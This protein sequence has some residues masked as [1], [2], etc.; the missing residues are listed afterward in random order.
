MQN[1]SW[2]VEDTTLL[3]ENGVPEPVFAHTTLWRVIDTV[4]TLGRSFRQIQYTQ[5][6]LGRVQITSPRINVDMQAVIASFGKLTIDSELLVPYHLFATSEDR[7]EITTPNGEVKEG[8]HQV[9]MHY[10][11][12]EIRSPDP[13]RRLR[14][15]P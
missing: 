15:S 1:Q 7:L 4:D 14:L 11:L 13:D 5:T 3:V 9:S 12:R 2:I 10:R 6:A 8:K